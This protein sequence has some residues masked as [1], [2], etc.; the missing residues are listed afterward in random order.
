MPINPQFLIKDAQGR[1]QPPDWLVTRL[2]R[3]NPGVG[4]FYTKAAWAITEAWRPDDPRRQWIQRGEMQPEYAFD[5]CG[6]LPVTC[7][8]LEAPAFIEQMLR[9]YDQTKW[10]GI[11]R[12][13]QRWNFEDGHGQDAETFEAVMSAVSN[14]LDRSNIVSPGAYIA[15][16]FDLPTA[17]KPAEPP[18]DFSHQ[19]AIS[20]A[21]QAAA[22]K[23][24]LESVASAQALL[25]KRQAE[26]KAHKVPGVAS[27]DNRDKTD[28]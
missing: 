13:A 9:G 23:A 5:I 16:P 28:K 2:Q 26:R 19:G 8:L 27:W 20:A 10:Q 4:L 14:D 11:R 6:Y 17:E 21:D 15:V 7:S 18:F 1:P 25:A 3:D 22:D 12:A 24:Q